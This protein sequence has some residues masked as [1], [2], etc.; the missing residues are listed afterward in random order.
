MLGD[1][2]CL[3]ASA[4]SM[5]TQAIGAAFWEAAVTMV[6]VL[7]A[8]ACTLALFPEPGPAVLAV[9]LCLSLSR[10]QLDRDLRGRLEALVMLPVV[11]LVATGIGLMLLH[12]PWVGAMV[13]TLG[14]A[15]SIWLRQFG[16]GARR[17]GSLIALPLV[18]ILVTP[19]APLR[20]ASPLVVILAPIA[21]A[22]IALSWVTVLHLLAGRLRVLARA[23][24]QAPAPPRSPVPRDSAKLTT[25]TRMAVQMAM[26][27]AAAFAVGH[28]FFAGHWAWIVLTAFIV[29]SGNRGRLD[30]AC[31]SFLRIGGAGLGTVLALAAA[32]HVGSHDAA[33]IALILSAVFMGIWL[34][35]LGYAWWAL[36]A[37]IALALLQGFEG[38]SAGAILWP[39]L[40]AIVVG[41]VIGVAAAW[42]VLPVRS[43]DVLR[44]RL[45]DAL[46]RMADAFDPAAPTRCT[47]TADGEGLRTAMA[48][49]EQV[50]KAFRAT[51]RLTTRLRPLQPARWA[52]TLLACEE[53]A[54][55]LI[56]RGPAPASVRRAI[57]AARKALREPRH[58]QDALEELRRSLETTCGGSSELSL[59][60]TRRAQG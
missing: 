27:L 37:T 29:N 5:N 13:Y 48:R 22:L 1:P 32:G 30:V 2:D 6:A 17:A 31:K 42:L 11:G 36:F 20:H 16:P 8:L 57:G 3:R 44:R 45:A 33:T 4:T 12:L 15:A 34:R 23:Q 7:A 21:V 50:A 60:E 52:D 10:S 58:L 14:M 35:P 46:A 56:E 19:H 28:A 54:I 9:V 41:A 59:A 39:R 47:G 55:A 53:P 25:S 40:G 26:A 43:T 18:A 51:R 49:I 38:V 24:P